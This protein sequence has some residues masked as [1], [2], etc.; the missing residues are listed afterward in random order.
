MT[1]NQL[2]NEERIFFLLEFAG[3]LV[4]NSAKDKEL[5]DLIEA[6]KI[7]MKYLEKDDTFEEF[8]KTFLFNEFEPSKFER[9]KIPI[10]KRFFTK[11]IRIMKPLQDIKKIIPQI[12][13]KPIF[14][15]PIVKPTS[16]PSLSTSS[17]PLSKIDMLLNDIG[18][19]LL[20]CPGP[21]RNILVKVRNNIN[22][23][24][25]TLNNDEI[26]GIIDYFS[27][28]ANI[29]IVGGIL[30]AAVGDMIISAI[31]SEFVGSR[32]IITKKSP[33]SLIG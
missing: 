6:E 7:K 3:E 11:P 25:V 24:R 14:P 31:S 4:I 17:S 12:P 1:L 20:E 9:E 27:K 23:T 18:L 22:T 29:P 15:K 30:K 19:Q 2:N 10:K 32:F 13:Y 28:Q 8:G 26:K 5:R 21:G 33:Y 16:P